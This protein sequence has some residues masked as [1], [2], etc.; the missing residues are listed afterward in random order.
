MEARQS[1]QL[2]L[3]DAERTRLQRAISSNKGWDR[4]LEK[5]LRQEEGSSSNRSTANRVYRSR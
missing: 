2:A 5:Q 4:E 1:Y 3:Q